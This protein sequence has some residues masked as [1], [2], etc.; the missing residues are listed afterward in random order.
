M[1]TITSSVMIERLHVN[2]EAAD[3]WVV[4]GFGVV[5]EPSVGVGSSVKSSVSLVGESERLASES[6]PPPF[7]DRYAANNVSNSFFGFVVDLSSFTRT[8]FGMR[9]ILASTYISHA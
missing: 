7:S 6:E 5:V 4:L 9:A 3:G 8:Q 1:V 2:K